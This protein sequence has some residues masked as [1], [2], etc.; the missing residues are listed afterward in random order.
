[1]TTS[2]LVDASKTRGL[3]AYKM[4]KAQLLAQ[5]TD[6]ITL[7]VHEQ[8]PISILL[9][10]SALYTSRDPLPIINKLSQ[11]VKEIPDELVLI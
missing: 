6:W 3:P 10:T 11:A 2:E 1:M 5:L 4:N 7:S 9:F 8:I